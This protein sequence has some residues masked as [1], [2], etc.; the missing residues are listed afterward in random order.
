MAEDQWRVFFFRQWILKLCSGNWSAVLS[1][2]GTLHS[3]VFEVEG[4]Y[5]RFPGCELLESQSEALPWRTRE[6]ITRAYVISYTHSWKW[7]RENF[8][9][10]V[11]R[12]N[13]LPIL[14][15][16]AFL[17]FLCVS[18]IHFP[19]FPSLSLSTHTHTHTHPLERTVLLS[20]GLLGRINIWSYKIQWVVPRK[21]A[22]SNSWSCF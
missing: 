15:R 22:L 19:P 17:F 2:I 10:G 14:I 8:I 11:S 12:V 21:G 4:D 16:N 18:P 3:S 6:H 9:S 20:E 13:T 1:W 5:I 7:E